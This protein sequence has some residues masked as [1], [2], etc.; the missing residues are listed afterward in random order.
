MTYIAGL[1]PLEYQ[2]I[3]L[4]ITQISP[5]QFPYLRG[6]VSLTIN[7]TGNREGMREARGW[8][9]LWWH[10]HLK[11]INCLLIYGTVFHSDFPVLILTCDK[12]DYHY[13]TFIR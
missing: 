12:V 4:I 1:L 2:A 3:D 8:E 6:T 7:I 9:R 11:V 10:Y 5:T 13:A